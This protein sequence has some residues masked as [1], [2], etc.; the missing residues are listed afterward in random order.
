MPPGG[1]RTHD[2]SR[3]EAADLSL[4]PRGYWDR[5]PSYL[6]IRE[7]FRKEVA[8]KNK[9]N[10]LYP[11]L[12]SARVKQTENSQRVRVVTQGKHILLG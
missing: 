3:R 11:I 4:R 8:G 9:T 12:F 5:P 7:M 6:P 2:L 10:A 1:I